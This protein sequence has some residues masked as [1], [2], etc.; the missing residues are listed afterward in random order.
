MN[1]ISTEISLKNSDLFFLFYSMCPIYAGRSNAQAQ[2]DFPQQWKK[3]IGLIKKHNVKKIQRMA[4]ITYYFVLID[5][6]LILIQ[7]SNFHFN[8]NL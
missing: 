6:S 3:G 2:L 7:M 8:K 1:K 5:L 4:E